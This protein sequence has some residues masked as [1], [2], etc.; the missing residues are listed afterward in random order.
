MK[1]R[2][3]RDLRACSLKRSTLTF[4]LL[5]CIFVII[6]VIHTIYTCYL[7]LSVIF[8]IMNATPKYEYINKLNSKYFVNFFF[9]VLPRLLS[10]ENNTTLSSF[11]F[12]NNTGINV[13]GN[14]YVH[15][16]LLN[17]SWLCTS[18]QKN[19]SYSV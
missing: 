15:A 11:F 4:L 18:F 13:L 6:L 16:C 7:K 2:A 12:E 3:H 10:F 14:N 8:E 1:C 17:F 19:T 9:A 5:E